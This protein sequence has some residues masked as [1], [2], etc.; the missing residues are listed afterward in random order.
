M[1]LNPRVS[2]D[3]ILMLVGVKLSDIL[4]G[5]ADRGDEV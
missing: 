5:E 1:R 2:Y 4:C 3:S